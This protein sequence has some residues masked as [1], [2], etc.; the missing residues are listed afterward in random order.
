MNTTA[1]AHGEV[2]TA[3]AQYAAEVRRHLADLPHDQVDDLA[4]GLEADLVDALEDAPADGDRVDLAARFGE[5][6]AY[7]RE[8]RAAAGLPDESTRRARPWP[9]GVGRAGAATVAGARRVRAW[10]R[11]QPWSG[12]V[13]GAGADL[14][15]LWWVVR[16]WIAYQVVM[17][18]ALEA[19]WLTWRLRPDR[20]GL[21]DRWLHAAVLLVL[22]AVS[23]QWG[24]RR[25]GAGQ[26][27]WLSAAATAL[28]L[29]LLV[30][31]AVF[32]YESRFYAQV[33]RVQ[34]I[35]VPTPVSTPPADGVW[36][37]GM[38]VSNL[39]VYD[40]AGDPL[41]D[42]Q[43][44]DDR[45]RPVRTVTDGGI[46]TWTFPGVDEAWTFVPAADSEGRK[47]WNAYPLRGAPTSEFAWPADGTLPR[48]GGDART[49]PAPF[50]KAPALVLPGAPSTRDPG[51]TSGPTA[52]DEADTGS[53][54]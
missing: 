14:R 52:G 40:A 21:P 3:V 6:H 10:A 44:Y 28:A 43:V 47:R 32:T 37:G 22:V 38:Q 7:A 42:V 53:A 17:W 27:P 23:V 20:D 5:P 34:Y 9:A 50:A 35:E 18:L 4:D 29:V 49:P 11:R 12:P 16:G 48:L 26:L 15:P 36:V 39:F 46:G 51:P 45:G 13:A 1:A 25:W 19:D 30:P 31:V 24:R 8:L 2:R 41:H 33:D 54:P